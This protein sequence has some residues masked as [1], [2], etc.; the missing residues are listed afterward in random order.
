MSGRVF[1]AREKALNPPLRLN[2]KMGGTMKIF[3]ITTLLPLLAGLLFAALLF[4][5]GCSK[6]EVKK[7]PPPEV[8]VANEAFSAIEELR[9]A[10]IEKNDAALKAL[11]TENGYKDLREDMK[12]FDSAELKFTPRW[13]DIKGETVTVN[14]GWQGTWRREGK[15]TSER[16]MA[17]FEFTGKPL[18]FNNTLKGS[19]F[20]YP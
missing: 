3:K 9:K 17:V 1:S 14:V 8:K 19:P 18:K 7:Q 15:E 4:A 11:S 20:I 10:Y 12:P 5:P 13:V 2:L 16:G 6:K